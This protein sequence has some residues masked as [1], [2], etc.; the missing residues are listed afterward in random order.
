MFG[1]LK[2]STKIPSFFNPLKFKV[3]E[4]N[5]WPHKNVHFLFPLSVHTQKDNTTCKFDEMGWN[6]SNVHT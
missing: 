6:G 1:L 2:N 5:L 4:L 3:E